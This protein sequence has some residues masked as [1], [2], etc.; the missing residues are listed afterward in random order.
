[1]VLFYIKVLQKS[2]LKMQKKMQIFSRIF[3]FSSKKLREEFCIFSSCIEITEEFSFQYFYLS[4][5]RKA[6]GNY[7]G[8]F[9]I[10]SAMLLR[11]L[12]RKTLI[13]RGMLPKDLEE[14]RDCF[15]KNFI[16]ILLRYYF[17]NENKLLEDEIEDSSRKPW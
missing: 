10:F 12:T 7:F 11:G 14:F 16:I 2:L 3:F 13:F 1:M 4:F 6:Y 5:F 8:N 17:K 15:L 9:G